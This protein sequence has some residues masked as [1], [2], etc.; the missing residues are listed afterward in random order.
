MNVI[1]TLWIVYKTNNCNRNLVSE[2]DV[3]SSRPLHRPEQTS[4]DA[5]GQSLF[6]CRGDDSLCA[7][8]EKYSM[9]R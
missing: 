7:V 9:Y 2:A 3:I 8:T 6:E 1:S 4:A 5:D